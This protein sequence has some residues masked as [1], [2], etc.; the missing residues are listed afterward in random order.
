MKNEKISFIWDTIVTEIKGGDAM[1]KLSLENKKT[2]EKS[3]VAFDGLFI[4]IGHSPNSDMFKGQLKMN[5]NGYV[6][7][8]DRHRTNLPGVF[9]AGEIH[10]SVYRQV[11]TSAGMG[12]AAG[13]EARKFLENEEEE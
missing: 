13:I 12:A 11:V 7:V 8:D 2:G 5:E 3:E 9:A 6:E 1:E 10:D 4:F